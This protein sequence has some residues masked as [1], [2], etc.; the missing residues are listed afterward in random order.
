MG[1]GFSNFYEQGASEGSDL[2]NGIF[3]ILSGKADEAG[4]DFANVGLDIKN[5]YSGSHDR[6]TPPKT[7]DE[8]ARENYNRAIDPNQTFNVGNW[9]PI[10]VGSPAS[11]F[12]PQGPLGNTVRPSQLLAMSNPVA[13]MAIASSRG[14]TRTNLV[15]AASG[16]DLKFAQAN[17]G[18]IS[19]GSVVRN[20][21]GIA[22]G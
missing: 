7:A 5:A 8:I 21:P 13:R 4:Q 19:T 14:S 11:A 9:T 2:F 16:I 6:I 15:S 17:S 22:T 10:T 12:S 1:N 18:G 20:T 3:A